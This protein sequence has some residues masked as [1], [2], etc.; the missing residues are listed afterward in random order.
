MNHQ[1]SKTKKSN[2]KRK[3]KNPFVFFSSLCVLWFSFLPLL[4]AASDPVAQCVR[5]HFRLRYAPHGRSL[6]GRN[7]AQ[8]TGIGA[9]HGMPFR[10]LRATV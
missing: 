2:P 5:G 4:G 9:V 6:C 10:V 3:T 8:I 7:F 1:G